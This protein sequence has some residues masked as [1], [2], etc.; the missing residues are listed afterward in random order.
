MSCIQHRFIAHATLQRWVFCEFCGLG[1]EITLETKARSQQPRAPRASRK[2]PPRPSQ[3]PLNFETAPPNEA[4][5]LEAEALRIMRGMGYNV[6]ETAE[7]TV[8]QF[9]PRQPVPSEAYDV[10]I[11]SDT[12]FSG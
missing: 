11:A 10:D 3:L 9:R 7:E 12:T 2:T 1:K 4:N 6:G 8:E 5:A